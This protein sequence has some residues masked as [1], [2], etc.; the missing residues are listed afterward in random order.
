MST[1]YV[2]L[3]I[4]CTNASF[5]NVYIFYKIACLIPYLRS[6]IWT[7]VLEQNPFE[8]S[9]SWNSPCPISSISHRLM[10]TVPPR[11]QVLQRYKSEST[12][13]KLLISSVWFQMI[14]DLSLNNTLQAQ[15]NYQVLAFCLHTSLFSCTNSK[16]SC[17][18]G[19]PIFIS[20]LSLSCCAA[21]CV[22]PLPSLQTPTLQQACWNLFWAK[23]GKLCLILQACTC[24]LR[25]TVDAISLLLHW[26][27]C[28]KRWWAPAQLSRSSAAQQDAFSRQ[29]G[30]P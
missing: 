11:I 29:C 9:E 30:Q 21:V 23:W 3:E 8:S 12:H 5:V 22:C 7:S 24:T 19:R 27:E 28:W 13:I 2:F 20:A 25:T 17:I 16:P 18:N 1:Q 15:D 10:K 14:L 4:A 6:Q 26:V